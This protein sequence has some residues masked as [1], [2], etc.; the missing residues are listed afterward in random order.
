MEFKKCDNEIF[1]YVLHFD[2]LITTDMLASIHLVSVVC[3][4]TVYL[5]TA[6]EK[7]L[8]LF[9][10]EKAVKLCETSWIRVS[11]ANFSPVTAIQR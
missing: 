9:T 10:P 6:S 7:C 2:P 11:E 4:I 8:R 1:C 3:Q 5:L